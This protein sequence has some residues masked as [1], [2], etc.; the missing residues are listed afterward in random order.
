M[1]EKGQPMQCPVCNHLNTATSVRCLQ[2]GTTLIHEAVGHSE[3][4]RAAV[5]GRDQ[6]MY[7]RV[8]AILGFALVAA[9]LKTVLA[10]LWLSDTEVYGYAL[11]GAVAGAF[12][13]RLFLR[14]KR[15]Y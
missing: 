5:N 2:C 7:G 14:S 4:Y 12:L 13:G 9:L 8:G 3:R 10:G 11:G 1:T 6:R 15:N